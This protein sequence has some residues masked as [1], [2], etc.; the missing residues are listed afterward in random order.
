MF[1]EPVAL[2]AV[3]LAFWV[4]VVATEGMLISLMY[5]PG[6]TASAEQQSHSGDQTTPGH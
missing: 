5:G 4:I 1:G 6:R 3:E 2:V